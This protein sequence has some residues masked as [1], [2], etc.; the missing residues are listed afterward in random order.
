[1]VDADKKDYSRV[2]KIAKTAGADC[3]SSNE[4]LAN[5][6]VLAIQ[7]DSHTYWLRMTR[8]GKLILTK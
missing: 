4:L 1:M 8:T 6:K 7:H 3:V 2:V 5:S